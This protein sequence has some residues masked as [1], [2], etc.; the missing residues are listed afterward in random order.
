M[1]YR[2]KCV[3]QHQH[4]RHM[5]Y[6]SQMYPTC[7]NI[8]M[9]KISVKLMRRPTG[10]PA[11]LGRCFLK[12]EMCFFLWAPQ[13]FP[14]P[15]FPCCPPPVVLNEAETGVLSS[16][17]SVSEANLGGRCRLECDKSICPGLNLYANLK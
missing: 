2:I 17:H 7:T 1:L 9:T 3:Q 12:F 5:H 14:I 13:H 10:A 4:C 6:F 15:L 8:A 16:S 11:A